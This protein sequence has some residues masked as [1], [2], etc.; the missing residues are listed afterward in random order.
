MQQKTTV[1]KMQHNC[2][3]VAMLLIKY[4]V[5]GGFVTIDFRSN[6]LRQLSCILHSKMQTPMLD[7]LQLKMLTPMGAFCSGFHFGTFYELNILLC[8]M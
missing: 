1:C 2:G 7:I 4:Q 5:I 3:K 6:G 8:K